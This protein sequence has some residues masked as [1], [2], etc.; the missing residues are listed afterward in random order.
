MHTSSSRTGVTPASL[1]TWTSMAC[2]RW[3]SSS[4]RLRISWGG[5]Q[6]E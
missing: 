1:V 6:I 5:N 2:V 4:R 3:S